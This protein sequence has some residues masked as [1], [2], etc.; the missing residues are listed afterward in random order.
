MK[1]GRLSCFLVFVAYLEVS[2]AV[3]FSW[4]P[5]AAGERYALI[6]TGA[7]GGAEYAKKYETL[8]ISFVTILREK[9]GYAED[10]VIVLADREEA[11]V[12][13]ATRDNVRAALD[14]LKRRVAKDDVVLVLLVGHG[15]AQGPEAHQ[16]KFNLVGPDLS[17]TE[18]ADLVSPIA[19]RLV[20]VNATGGSFPFLQGMSARGRVVLTATKSTA[21]RFETVFPE[22]FV[23]AFIDDSADL[24]KNG[25]V[26]IW[27]A[28]RYASVGVENWFKEEGRLATERALLDD[29]GDGIGREADTPGADGTIAQVTYL[30]RDLLI[31][32]GDSELAALARR[33]VELESQI[34]LFKARRSTLAPERYQMELE[35]LLLELARFDRQSRSKP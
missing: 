21:Q 14:D 10:K 3:L 6:V 29:S 9:F 8:R 19:G 2:A 1:S 25:R 7:S 27:E 22:F 31:A 26:S 33:R 30:Q 28:F 11:G 24:D 34:E 35:A 13:R 12:R 4:A 32:T 17:A 23:R 5:V 16:A 18:W 20:F 15:T